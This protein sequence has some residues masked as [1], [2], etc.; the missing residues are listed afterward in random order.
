MA[1]AISKIIYSVWFYLYSSKRGKNKSLVLEIRIAI[2][3]EEEERGLLGFWS[4]SNSWSWWWLLGYLYFVII[5]WSVY[6]FENISTYLKIF[7]SL[8]NGIG[9]IYFFKSKTLKGQTLNGVNIIKW[10]LGYTSFY[11]QFIKT[12]ALRTNFLIKLPMQ[13]YGQGMEMIRMTRIL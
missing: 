3:L 2:N 7:K 6:L 1:E 10:I 4:W 13:I 12:W 5:H 8:I 11:W 9:Y